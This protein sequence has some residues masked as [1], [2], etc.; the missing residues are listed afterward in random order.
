MFIASYYSFSPTEDQV[1][2]CKS[3]YMKD[4]CSTAVKTTYIPAA[5]VETDEQSA[6][7]N[8]QDFTSPE[9]RGEILKTLKRR[10]VVFEST[11]KVSSLE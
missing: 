8:F 11:C 2:G 7:S 10:V 9:S 6:E 3:S 5:D 1:T 4:C